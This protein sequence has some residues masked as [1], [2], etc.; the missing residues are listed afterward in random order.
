MALV[1]V[2]SP[3]AIPPKVKPYTGPEQWRCLAWVVHDEARGEPLKGARAVLDVV[4]AR[5][6]ATGKSACEVIAQPRQFSGYKGHKALYELS[7]ETLR[8]FVKVAKMKPVAV[9]CK[10]FHATYVRPVWATKMRVCFRIGRHVFLK[11]IHKEKKHDNR[12]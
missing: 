9:E 10:H 5:M 2:C 1:L 4:L 12:K 7:D 11:E 8:R 3:L 6:K